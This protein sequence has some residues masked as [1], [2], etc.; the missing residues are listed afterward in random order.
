MQALKES[1]DTVGLRALAEVFSTCFKAIVR[2]LDYLPYRTRRNTSYEV[3]QCIVIFTERLF[4]TQALR[5]RRAEKDQQ[6]QVVSRVIELAEMTI[7]SLRGF[8]KVAERLVAAKKPLPALPIEDSLPVMLTAEVAEE[9]APLVNIVAEALR[10]E[11]TSIS[12]SSTCVP[13]SVGGSIGSQDAP[14]RK[15]RKLHRGSVIRYIVGKKSTSSSKASLFYH[16]T[17]SSATLVNPTPMPI[18]ES[19][20]VEIKARPA[21][22]VYVPRQSA[23]Y[24]LADPYCP[25]VDVEMPVP[26]GECVAVRLDQ[27]G[28]MKAASLP[29]LVRILTSKESVLDQ[30]FTPTFFICFRFFTTPLLFFQELVKRFD[31]QPAVDL[32]PAQLRIWTQNA[33][34]VHIRVGKAILMWLDLYWKPEVDF[35]VLEPLQAF[36]LD[37]LVQELPEGM[38]T[39]ILEGLDS[40]GGEEPI[41]RRTQK[42]KDLE[43]IF[44]QTVGDV[45]P[46]P[47][48]DLTSVMMG[49]TFQLIAFN[50]PAGR[51][52]FARQLTANLSGRF[53]QVDPEDA[54]LHWHRN[55]ESDVGKILREIISLE[56]SLCAWVT[57]TVLDRSTQQERCEILEFWLDIASVCRPH[58]PHDILFDH[59]TQRCLRLRNFS[60]TNCIW[61]GVSHGAIYRMKQTILVGCLFPLFHLS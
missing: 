14:P 26:T 51:Q 20:E 32:N 45:P 2:S 61:G 13:E 23:L 44:Q 3:S 41:C 29:A 28:E 55:D 42:A 39:H 53:Q 35:E 8:L 59:F 43:F 36:A 60:S 18:K 19:F 25:E 27:H 17:K 40:V 46:T 50:T 10:D 57:E 24:Y 5:L 16:K 38:V 22:P 12:A 15:K 31:E 11:T 37:R 30:D 6:T 21:E 49:S 9:T 1:E 47:Q 7:V 33:V 48:F 54:V 56:R 58:L 4:A 34:G 52:E